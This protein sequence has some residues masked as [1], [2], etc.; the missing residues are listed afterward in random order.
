MDTNTVFDLGY[1]TMFLQGPVSVSQARASPTLHVGSTTGHHSRCPLPYFQL[2]A[3]MTGAGLGVI[4]T[5]VTLLAMV[6]LEV[7]CAP[8]KQSC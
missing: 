1:N 6:Q 5:A 4:L 8:R 7:T 3:E 2:W